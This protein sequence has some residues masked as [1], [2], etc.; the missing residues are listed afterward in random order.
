MK[1]RIV[2]RDWKGKYNLKKV[3]GWYL[4]GGEKDIDTYSDSYAMVFSDEPCKDMTPQ[5]AWNINMVLQEEKDECEQYTS[6][7]GEQDTF[8][9]IEQVGKVN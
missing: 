8:K 7:E 1:F 2:T 3:L 9:N 4:L 6:V 5:K